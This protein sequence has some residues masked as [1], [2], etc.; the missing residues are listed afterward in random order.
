MFLRNYENTCHDG[1]SSGL[2][3]NTIYSNFLQT[4]TCNDYDTGRL[5]MID[6]G[7][8]QN[9]ITNSSRIQFLEADLE[10]EP[11]FVFRD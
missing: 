10:Q 8:K 3:V 1:S 4:H 2:L 9:K 11:S 7:V 5:T 6:K